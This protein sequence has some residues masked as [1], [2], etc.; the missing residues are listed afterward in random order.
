MV[1]DHVWAH[2]NSVRDVDEQH[3]IDCASPIGDA[4]ARTILDTYAR[5]PELAREL[6]YWLSI[7]A[8]VRQIQPSQVQEAET[9]RRD[10]EA[11]LRR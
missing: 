5:H 6:R 9:L 7:Q 2:C 8:V 3:L 4:E 1:Q 11:Y 10:I